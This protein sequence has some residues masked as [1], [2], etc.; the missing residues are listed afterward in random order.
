M[1]SLIYYMIIGPIGVAAMIVAF[2]M[3]MIINYPF[4][5][6]WGA[7]SA[8]GGFVNV[9]AVQTGWKLVRDVCNMFFSLILVIIA[10][11]TVLKIEAYSWKQML[12][13][14]VLMAVLINFSK[15]ICGIFTDMATVAMATFGGS[16]GGTFAQGLVG[17]FGL[18]SFGAFGGDAS[19]GES[20]FSA[21]MLAY[22]A[23]AIMT[24]IFFVVMLSFTVVLLFRIVM[25]WFL[26]VLSPI[27]YIT[28]I[29]PQTKK[30]SSQWWEMFGRYVV[31]GPLV[32]FFLWLSLTMAF[33][34]EAI[35]AGSSSGGNPV[36]V[37]FS[38]ASSLSSVPGVPTAPSGAAQAT[39]P[40]V[41]ANFLIATMLLMA[42]LK[43]IHQMAAE[44]GALTGAVEK[45]A[46]GAGAALMTMPGMAM[47][48]FGAGWG[49][50]EGSGFSKALYG[51]TH[52]E[53]DMKNEKGEKLYM[54][55]D[56]KVTTDSTKGELM[57]EDQIGR[58]AKIATT[59]GSTVFQPTE[60]AKGL[61]KGRQELFE[62]KK[63]E[64][65]E[66]AEKG[67]HAMRGDRVGGV[68]DTL[69]GSVSRLAGIVTG[70]GLDPTHVSREY[71]SL[72]GAARIL[73]KGALIATGQLGKIE[74]EEKKEKEEKEKLRSAENRLRNDAEVNELPEVL[75]QQEKNK[76]DQANM[77][78]MGAN[79]SAGQADAIVYGDIAQVKGV[80]QQEIEELHRKQVE[81]LD[82]GHSETAKQLGGRAKQ[83]SDMIKD[84]SEDEM[85]L[86][87][88]DAL[89]GPERS[90]Q[91]HTN[92]GKAMQDHNETLKK[93]GDNIQ[94]RLTESGYV[95][96]KGSGVGVLSNAVKLEAKK[97]PKTDKIVVDADG[98]AVIVDERQKYAEAARKHSAEAGRLRTDL[99]SRREGPSYESRTH[100]EHM[101]NEEM[102][103][104]KGVKN[105]EELQQY[106]ARALREKNHHLYEAVVKRIAQN[107]DFNEIVQ[108]QMADAGHPDARSDAEGLELWRKKVLMGKLGMD[109]HESLRVANDLSYIEEEVGHI[110]AARA[111]RMV[112]GHL[113]HV[114]EK[115]RAVIVAGEMR[116]A[117]IN[118]KL[119]WNRLA[120]GYEDANRD[121]QISEAGIKILVT[122]SEAMSQ[123]RKWENM[124]SN[125]KLKLSEPRIIKKLKAAGV[126]ADFIRLLE[127]Y[128]NS[129]GQYQQGDNPVRKGA[130]RFSVYQEK[131]EDHGH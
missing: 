86:T 57:K 5:A 47:Q 64:N 109:E 121:F 61:Y 68:Q 12:P 77:A 69:L 48:S 6:L 108:Q 37:G 79:L 111:Y 93:E 119:K 1:G 13:K 44:A 10:L 2:I 85:L 129:T 74:A 95:E 21:V 76:V 123:P 18:T 43:L 103:K 130:G 117:D 113:H 19:V 35:G 51:L 32:T 70:A 120:W 89:V 124:A 14:L 98:N 105:T 11:A 4:G 78:A 80:I 94:K 96:G 63:K 102:A 8:N 101:I 125:A 34:T 30:Y 22:I 7:S 72:G 127:Q 106:L 26:I 73:G 58:F 33:G 82:G 91:L 92:L 110:G 116:K 122:D 27:A 23:A 90:G 99:Q 17:A 3:Q 71:L 67:A 65:K 131:E 31:V 52:R 128:W 54:G 75:A 107:Y 83:L 20:S 53:R 38:T 126:N 15:T 81:A 25:L 39:S 42:S 45:G 104:I 100:T 28:R 66:R 97:D 112:N 46:W 49:S 56:G 40:N 84:G 41:L 88:V 55:K 87:D 114:P 16:F 50:K 24:M 118:Q 62:E 36:G 29:L 115:E 9:S 60:W 59:L